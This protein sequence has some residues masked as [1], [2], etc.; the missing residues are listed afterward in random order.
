MHICKITRATHKQKP[1]HLQM[2]T[3]FFRWSNKLSWRVE[4]DLGSKYYVLGMKARKNGNAISE[5]G[6]AEKENQSNRGTADSTSLSGLST[7]KFKLIFS[8]A[9]YHCSNYTEQCPVLQNSTTA[10]L[11][12]CALVCVC[13][14]QKEW[15]GE[16]G[17]EGEEPN[18]VNTILLEIGRLDLSSTEKNP[19]VIT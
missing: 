19:N 1:N 15:Q 8:L 14:R 9:C 7:A 3:S 17:R 6:W 13:E 12:V 2:V 5:L 16:G 4:A 11:C 18:I 10:T